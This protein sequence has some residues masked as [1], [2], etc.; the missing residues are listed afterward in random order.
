M[1][2]LYFLMFVGV[3]V[4]SSCKHTIEYPPVDPDPTDTTSEH[5][6]DPDTVYFSRDILPILVSNCAMSGCHDPGTAQNGVVLNNYSNVMATADV[7][8]GDPMGSDIYEVLID[9]DVDDRMPFGMPPL[10]QDQID[11]IKK[12]ILQGG[13]NLTCVEEGCDTTSVSYSAHIAPLLQNKCVGCHG[14]G[15]TTGVTLDNHAGVSTVALNGRLYGAVN[16]SAGFNPMPQGGA[17]LPDCEISII[18]TWINNGAPD[19]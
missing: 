1:R 11:L 18:R 4:F 8:P 16:H 17:K 15:N 3:L 2:L 5:F 13:L 10:S 14:A 7:R 19:N 12:W 9:P 6:C